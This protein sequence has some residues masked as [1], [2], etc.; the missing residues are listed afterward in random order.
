MLP[1]V[2]Y[3]TSL[4]AHADKVKRMALLIGNTDYSFAPLKNPVNDASDLGSR[5]SALGFQTTL[6]TNPDSSRIQDA[7]K[8]FYRKVSRDPDALSVF[9]YAGHAVQMNNVNYL[10]PVDA[11]ITSQETLVSQSI[12]IND[13]LVA[14][15]QTSNQKNL[16]IL[17]ACRT[18]PFKDI[19]ADKSGR[20]MDL[21]DDSVR[22]LQQGLA[23]VEAPAGTII[24]YATAPGN[25]AKDGKG[26][27]GTYTTYLLKHLDKHHPVEQIFKMVRE[28]VVSA[29]Q[30]K[31]IP[32]EHSSLYK[33]VYFYPPRNE[34]IPE[35][36]GF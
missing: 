10:I 8:D 25:V 31:Q 11:Q 32:W 4:S 18:N 30:G 7:I 12:S 17:D 13:L 2:L 3:G 26:R 15:K 6:L 1:L 36:G 27:N 22:K 19:K 29:T 20:S 33:Q 34:S 9:Y 23:P 5:L 28:D 24:A 14:M 16:V 21:P 35:I